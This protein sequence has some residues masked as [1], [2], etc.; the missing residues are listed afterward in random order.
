M[1]ALLHVWLNALCVAGARHRRSPLL[2]NASA[3]WRPRL[4]SDGVKDQMRLQSLSLL[5]DT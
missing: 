3:R 5:N 2:T 1:L 4:L